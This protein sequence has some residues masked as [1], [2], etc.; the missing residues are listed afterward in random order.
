VRRTGRWLLLG[1]DDGWGARLATGPTGI[2][3]LAALVIALHALDL[4]TGL[5][6]MLTHGVQLELN[7]LARMIMRD[8][9]PY[10][11]VA[12]KLGVVVCGVI[13]FVRTAQVGRARL[14]RNCL[15]FAAGVGILG[16]ASNL[17]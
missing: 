3:L 10:G 4:A 9:G 12:A 8:V 16:A 5:R 2:Y 1:T 14:A 15:I 11:L 6:M 13:L 17:I 7:P